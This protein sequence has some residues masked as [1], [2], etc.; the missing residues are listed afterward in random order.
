MSLKLISL[1]AGWRL[2]ACVHAR[3]QADPIVDRSEAELL[4]HLALVEDA[5]GGPF[6][7]CGAR[8]VERR[9]GLVA[10]VAKLSGVM[11]A[12]GVSTDRK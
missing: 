10:A 2:A 11:K 8:A 6:A 7:H 5:N 3:G 9:T 12:R 1:L 4:L